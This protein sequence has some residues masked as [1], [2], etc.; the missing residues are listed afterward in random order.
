MPMWAPST[1]TLMADVTAAL[2]GTTLLGTGASM[3]MDAVSE[4]ICQPVVMTIRRS[5]QMPAV[6]RVQTQLSDTHVVASLLV[7]PMRDGAL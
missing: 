2:L 6:E 5:V 3:V 1:V 4:L 7:P